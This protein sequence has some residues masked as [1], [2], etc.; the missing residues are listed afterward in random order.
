MGIAVTNF[1]NEMM[2]LYEPLGRGF[3]DR[4][5][6]AGVGAASRQRLGFGCMFAD[7][8]LD[9]YLDLIAANG[10]IDDTIRSLSRGI[11]H[12]QVANLFHDGT[13]DSAT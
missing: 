2:G 13:G 10:H 4:A 8:N 1:D 5:V 12:E 11:P 9:G 3:T 6:A 7:F